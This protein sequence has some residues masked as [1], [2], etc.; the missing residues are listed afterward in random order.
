MPFGWLVG[1]TPMKCKCFYLSNPTSE[2]PR[3]EEGLWYW[4]VHSAKWKYVDQM[5]NNFS[6]FFHWK[7]F[8]PNIFRSEVYRLACFLRVSKK[9]FSSPSDDE[10]C[11]VAASLDTQDIEQRNTRRA[12]LTRLCR[13]GLQM[14]L[15]EILILLREI[16]MMLM[17]WQG[18]AWLHK[19][20]QWMQFWDL[21]IR[22]LRLRISLRSLL[23]PDWVSSCTAWARSSRPSWPCFW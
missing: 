15:L 21:K 5:T 11:P 14:R 6:F 13:P 12:G 10:H 16:L 7:Y 2:S 9:V 4:V 20:F 23:S 19:S 22:C 17:F 1:H 8:G 18:H 3:H